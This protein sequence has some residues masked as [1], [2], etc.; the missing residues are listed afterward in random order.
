[1]HLN[2]FGFSEFISSV[3]SLI[4]FEANESFKRSS[5]GLYLIS[6]FEIKALA[7]KKNN[8]DMKLEL[9]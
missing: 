2:I 7:Y 9:S 4:I 1:M 5:G 6:G 8:L 3:Q